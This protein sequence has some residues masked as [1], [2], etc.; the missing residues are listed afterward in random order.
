MTLVNIYWYNNNYNVSRL[1]KVIYSHCMPARLL[2]PT[3]L[4]TAYIFNVTPPSYKTGPRQS[5]AYLNNC[6]EKGRR[7]HTSFAFFPWSQSNIATPFL[8]LLPT[9]KSPFICSQFP[10]ANDY[11]HVYYP[12]FCWLSWFWSNNTVTFGISTNTIPTLTTLLHCR[13]ISI[14]SHLMLGL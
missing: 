2:Y 1:F 14:G 5:S 3:Q 7:I 4:M 13:Y 12:K 8:P 6:L 10:L 11:A 9:T